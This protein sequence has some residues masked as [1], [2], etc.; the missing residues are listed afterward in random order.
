MK[1][2]NTIHEN[3]TNKRRPP[4][5]YIAKLPRCYNVAHV[6]RC[7]F[8]SS[9]TNSTINVNF[10]VVQGC[11]IKGWSMEANE[12]S[13]VSARKTISPGIPTCV[14]LV[15]DARNASFAQQHFS[16]RSCQLAT[17]DCAVALPNSS[18]TARNTKRRRACRLL[19]HH[20]LY[21]PR[22]RSCSLTFSAISAPRVDTPTSV[23]ETSIGWATPLS[24][25]RSYWQLPVDIP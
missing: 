12:R 15:T 21:Q 22:R 18:E 20:Q 6:H 17:T 3:S 2:L 11:A 25:P 7:L 24:A 23:L 5:T 19:N 8:C 16:T 4:A 1:P 9:Y 10:S 13:D 14:L